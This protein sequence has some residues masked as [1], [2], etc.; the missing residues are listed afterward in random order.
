MSPTKTDPRIYSIQRRLLSLIALGFIALLLII[1]VLFW[2]YARA[3]ANQTY[4]LLL[5]G[6]ALS[7]LE[8][9][10]PGTD[11]PTV[12][13]PFSAMDILAL[14]PDDRVVYRVFSPR[15]GEITG[16]A[17]LPMPE[18]A[19][20]AAASI[21]FNAPYRGG[22]F[23]FVVKGRTL[24]VPGGRE[25]VAVQIGQTTQARRAR[26]ISL[27]LNGMA[28]LAAISLIGLGFVWLAIRRALAPLRQIEAD[29]RTRE[30]SDRSHLKATPPR[31]IQSL[32]EAI[33][34]FI[35]RLSSNRTLTET[36]IADVA[37]QTRT[38]LSALQGQ[39]SLAADAADPGEM[40]DRMIKADR[41]AQRTVRLTN[42]LLA[43]A[44]VI[45]RTDQASLPPVA[46]K[47]LVR[48]QLAEMLRDSRM[49]GVTVT[50]DV[51]E[52]P[53]DTDV[54]AGDA[55]SIREALRNLIENALRHG[56]PD[57]TIDIDLRAEPPQRIAL[58]VAD[59][60][61]GIPEDQRARATERFTSLARD[62]AG[63]GLGLAIVRAVAEGHGAGLRLETSKKGGLRA[64]LSFPMAR[65]PGSGARGARSAVLVGL[66]AACLAW[67][68]PAGA[69]TRSLQV[70]SSTDTPAVAPLLDEFETRHPAIDLT[71]QEFQTVDLHSHMLSAA[72]DDTPD[73][74]ISSAMDLQVDLVNRGLARPLQ[75]V[76]AAALPDWAMW[77]SELYG[78]TFEPAAILYNRPALAADI[79]PRLHQ[80]LPRFIRENEARL[81]GRIGT[82]DLRRSG[83][84]YLYAT[85]D[86][87]QGMEAQRMME[88]L[89][90]AGVQ[91]FCCTAD[92]AAAAAAGDLLL[93]FNVI[94]SYALAA[95]EDD[96]RIG[97]HLLDDYNLVMTRTA[98]VPRGA[99]NPEDGERFVRFLL[100][101]EGQRL[102]ATRSQLLP[103]LPMPDVNTMPLRRLRAYEGS[104][105]PIRLG[106]GLLTYLDDLKRRRFLSGWEASIQPER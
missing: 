18:D 93:A 12:D 16:A 3:A 37:H 96:P 48:D 69:Q 40:R 61:P 98:F 28:G 36:F 67:T 105:L 62:S 86:L 8:R 23:R 46:L 33:N 55:L 87:V 73:V 27:F 80:D 97:V 81:M 38:S 53:D 47:P 101:Q 31:E 7:I 14:A 58:S 84:G 34:G 95:A 21:F 50:F 22:S 68:G 72:P 13:L 63:S 26:Q 52:F 42:Q 2:N 11:G 71:Y 51:D 70:F 88:V 85:Q 102:I 99:A 6:A 4:D 91:T 5:A 74:V 10:T 94:G 106:P 43:H 15:S 20:P 9:V 83:I 24:T 103:I 79:L 66:L 65:P 30:P 1:A 45:H 64:V 82:Y 75:S 59:A 76:E 32:F 19:A 104:F 56:P 29:L 57:N 35:E 41:Q 49:R 78:F 25:W 54:V 92:M 44:M 39:L 77:R 90:R 100:S 89:G 60:G 17:D